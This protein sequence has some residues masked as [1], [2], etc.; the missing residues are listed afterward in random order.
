[1]KTNEEISKHVMRKIYT[2]YV[3]R[4]IGQPVMRASIFVAALLASLSFISVPQ[5]IANVGT[6]STMTGTISFFTSAFLETELFVQLSLALAGIVFAW[7]AVDIVKNISTPQH[8][9]AV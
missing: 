3:M 5:V 8:A 1:M 7:S 4:Q 6:V 2:I 9:H